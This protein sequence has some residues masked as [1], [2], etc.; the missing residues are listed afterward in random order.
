MRTLNAFRLNAVGWMSL[1]VVVGVLVAPAVAPAVAQAQT[2]PPQSKQAPPKSQPKQDQ[3]RKASAD[4]DAGPAA[5]PAEAV[6]PLQQLEADAVSCR[7]AAEAVQ[8]YRIFLAN[9]KLPAAQRKQAEERLRHWEKLEEEKRLRLGKKWVTEDEFDEIN[10]KTTNMIMHSF[11]LLKL[12]QMKLAKEELMAASRLNPESGKADFVTG[13][14]YLMVANNDLKAAEHFSVVVHRE[15]NNVYALNN[16]AVAEMLCKKYGYATKHFRRALEIMPDCQALADNLGV[17][18]GAGGMTLKHRLP[19]KNASELNDLYRMAIHDLKLKPY[20]PRKGPDGVQG[21]NQGGNQNGGPGQGGPGGQGPGSRPRGM[22]GGPNGSSSPGGGGGQG[23]NG[24]GGITL[25]Y[26]I[27]TPYGRAMGSNGGEGAIK[28]LLDEPDEV[29]VGIA[30]GTGFVIAPGYV[31]TNRHVIEGASDL[32]ILDPIG[33]EKQMVATVVAESENPD[34]ALLRCEELAEVDTTPLNLAE[35][36][37]RR[38][39]DIMVLGYP[40]GSMLGLELKSTRGSITSATDAKVD[41]GSFLYSATVNPGNSGGPVI[42]QSGRVVGVVVAMIKTHQS[43]NT[44]SLGIPMERV[45][46]FLEEHLADLQPYTEESEPEEWPDVDER[47]GKSTVFITAKIKRGGKKKEPEQSGDNFAQGG[48]GGPPGG[49]GGP[50]GSGGGPPGSGGGPPGSGGGPPGSGSGPPGYAGA[51]NGPPG[52]TPPGYPGG[53]PGSVPPQGGPPPG[54]A[55]SAP[56]SGYPGA[57]GGAPGGP[58]QSGPPPG[59]PGGPPGGAPGGPPQSGPPPGY[60][61][62]PPGGAPGGPPQSGPPA[63]YPGGPPG[64]APGGPPQ[65]GPPAGYPGGPP[66][67]APGGPP[68]SGP[69]AGYPGGPPGGAPGG[70]PQSG[71]PAGYPGGPPGGAPGGPPQSGP[72]AGYPGGPP[73]GAPGGPPGPPTGSQSPPPPPGVTPQAPPR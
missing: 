30:T 67:G 68:Q 10:R 41:G 63:G 69:P 15:P 39:T 54:F 11:N 40:G 25:A 47:C 17:A 29:V 2:K 18:I 8:V 43:G 65:S 3:A 20:D 56:P 12:G 64:G 72:P 33:R 22:A 42:D 60:P 49:G 19:E 71:P 57:P 37:P 13:M 32:V 28:G 31:L 66:G 59:Y 51:P 23:G 58:P 73:G 62:G 38:G 14:V 36:L 16:L 44:Y 7:T 24:Q 45:W 70:P 21:G 34:L 26:T 50:P 4:D 55:G 5:D 6:D 35:K 46:P 52:S 53:P 48:G 61:G 1:F 27:M 9:Q